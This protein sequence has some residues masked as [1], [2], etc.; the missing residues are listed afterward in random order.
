MWWYH[1]NWVAWLAMT[2]GMLVFWGLVIWAFLALA[3]ASEGGGPRR[4]G[5]PREQAPEEI[6]AERFARGEIDEDDYRR[7]LEA[8]RKPTA[9]R[10]RNARR[11]RTGAASSRR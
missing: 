7:R 1:G 5:P 11:P 10:S 8:L 9:H 2:L 4:G 6:L 3:R